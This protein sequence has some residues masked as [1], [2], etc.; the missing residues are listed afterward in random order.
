MLRLSMVKMLLGAVVL[1]AMWLGGCGGGSGQGSGDAI[2]VGSMNS[3]TGLTATFGKSS[4]KGIRLAAE[5]Q[6]KAGGL[7]GKQVEIVTADTESSPEKT[8]NAILKL[9]EQDKVCA[10]LG[11]VASKLSLAAAPVAQRRQVPLLSPASTNPR[12]TQ[13]GDYIFRSC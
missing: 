6:N 5:E 1:G 3:M 2:K 7:L 9:I 13:V 4:D 8:P 10:V 12:V 11:E